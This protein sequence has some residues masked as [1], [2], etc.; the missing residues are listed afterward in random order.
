MQPT[1]TTALVTPF[2][3]KEL[4]SS[5]AS[6]ESFFADSIKP[7]VLITAISACAAS[8]IN[9]HPSAA[10]RPANSSES[11]SFRAQPIVMR[12]TVFFTTTNLPH[13]KLLLLHLTDQAVLV[14]FHLL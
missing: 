10:K 4:A 9:C 6:I 11:T 2:S 12:A 8:S 1:A 13:M 5:K 3:F 14:S 7:Q